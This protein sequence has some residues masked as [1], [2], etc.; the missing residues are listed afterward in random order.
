MLAVGTGVVAVGTA[1][2]D[3][4]RELVGTG[5]EG[6]AGS[7]APVGEATGAPDRDGV[8]LRGAPV[9]T[10]TGVARGSVTEHPR[11]GERAAQR[12]RRQVTRACRPVAVITTW[13]AVAE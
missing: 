7:G 3:A 11:A 13:T 6:C 8:T 12:P 10:G 9:A 2:E 4:L 1:A 5:A